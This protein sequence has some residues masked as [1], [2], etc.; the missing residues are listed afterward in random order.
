LAARQGL[1]DVAAVAEAQ[2][3]DAHPAGTT[4]AEIAN[5]QPTHDPAGGTN[6]DDDSDPHPHRDTAVAT[7]ASG[8][9]HEGVV[10]ARFDTARQP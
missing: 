5:G 4:N 9:E 10:I 7:R 8:E 6:H 1:R 2:L 3:E